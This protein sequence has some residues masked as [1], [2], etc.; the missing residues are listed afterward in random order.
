MAGMRR[1]SS[2]SLIISAVFGTGQVRCRRLVAPR[3]ERNAQP[4]EASLR[5]RE[6]RTQ[7]GDGCAAASV[8]EKNE[9]V[10]VS[11]EGIP[12]TVLQ[13]G[14]LVGRRQLDHAGP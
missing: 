2:Q 1:T 12:S 10:A 8:F 6:L 3:A 7:T 4:R 11:D 14:G 9:R 5:H 13:V